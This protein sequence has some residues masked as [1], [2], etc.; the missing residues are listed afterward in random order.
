VLPHG[1][2]CQDEDVRDKLG[3]MATETMAIIEAGGAPTY[4]ASASAAG[5][6]A[7]R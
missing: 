6:R 3:V 4:A 1:P 2:D 7:Q 5:V